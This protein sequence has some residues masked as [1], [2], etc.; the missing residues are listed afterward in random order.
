MGWKFLAVA[1]AAMFAPACA[2]ADDD[3]G[4]G[5]PHPPGGWA[6]PYVALDLGYHVPLAIDGTSVGNAPDGKPFQWRYK[7]N[8]DWDAFLR[9]GYRVT[10]HIRVEFD[11]GLRE[12]NINSIHSTLPEA[13][14]GLA[15]GRPGEPWGLCDLTNVPPPC[16]KTFGRPHVNWAYA[17]NGVINAVY[18]FAPQ[19]RFTPFVGVGVGIYHLQFDSHYYFS[20]VPGPY[21]AQNPAV[22][23]MQFGGSVFRVS[24]FAYQALAGVTYRAGRK[25]NV[26]FTYRYIEAPFLNWNT[27]N[28]TPGVNQPHGLQPGDVKGDARDVS[29]NVGL[30]YQL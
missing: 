2:F 22:Q 3:A 18:D 14:S 10:P 25:L 26:D 29:F 8:S 19:R 27:I 30:R 21:S 23:K 20:G 6:H 9:V 12:S 1:A 4:G 11:G 24:E 13:P 15:V 17:D 5:W 7:F 28:D 16:V